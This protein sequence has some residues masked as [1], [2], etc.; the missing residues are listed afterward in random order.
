MNS[1][2]RNGRGCGATPS[3]IVDHPSSGSRLAEGR[4]ISS[5]L[6]EGAC[7]QVVCRPLRQTGARWKVH[8]AERMATL[9]RPGWSAMGGI[10]GTSRLTPHPLL[11]PEQADGWVASPSPGGRV[12]SGCAVLTFQGR[13]CV[14]SHTLKR[15]P[16]PRP[17]GGAAQVAAKALQSRPTPQIRLNSLGRYGRCFDTARTQRNDCAVRITRARAGRRAEKV[18]GTGRRS[19]ATRTAIGG[20][21]LRPARPRVIHQDD[22]RGGQ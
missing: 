21:C 19:T 1:S 22:R 18:S 14:G 5:G 17:E 10:P 4:V 11:H 13:R 3:R 2:A 6:V 20:E 15:P 8:R 9:C 12:P 7:K 16:V